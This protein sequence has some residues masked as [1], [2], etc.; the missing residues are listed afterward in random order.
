[1][2]TGDVDGSKPNGGL[3]AQV[4][5]FLQSCLTMWTFLAQAGIIIIII[6]I[7]IVINYRNL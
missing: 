1:M 5:W 2:A 6:I 3:I 7:I 4:G